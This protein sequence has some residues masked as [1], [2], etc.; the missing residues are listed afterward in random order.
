M[1]N[2]YNN[3]WD[4]IERNSQISAAT[5]LEYLHILHKKFGNEWSVGSSSWISITKMLGFFFF[6]LICQDVETKCWNLH[7]S[8][9]S[10]SSVETE[11]AKV[12]VKSHEQEGVKM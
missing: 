10:T 6:L 3:E 11:K 1:S 8:L 9:I 12:M 5:Q 2:I 7:G 4:T